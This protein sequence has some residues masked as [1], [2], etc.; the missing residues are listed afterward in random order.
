MGNFCQML[1][2]NLEGWMASVCIILPILCASLS[3]SWISCV[4]CEG[5]F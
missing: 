3:M 5:V 2:G 1:F 4:S